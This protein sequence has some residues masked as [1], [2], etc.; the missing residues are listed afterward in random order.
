M[1][2]QQ[3]AL[4]VKEVLEHDETILGLAVA[5]S[6]LTDEIDEWSDLDLVVVTRENLN[7]DKEKMMAYANRF[8]NL[9]SGFT[10]EHVGETR[11]LIC[12]Y[13]EPLLHVDIKFVTADEFRERI[14][15]PVLLLDRNN[16]L[17]DI[18]QSTK[19]SFPSPDFQWIEDRFWIWIHYGL[20]KIGRGEYF[21]ALDFMGFLR[22]SVFGP[23]LHLR[24]NNLPRGVRKVET[25]LTAADFKLLSGTIAIHEKESLLTAVYNATELYKSLRIDLYDD[26]VSLNKA[27]VAVMTYFSSLR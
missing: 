11:L 1:I 17:Q 24:N 3:F 16:V 5:G 12:L 19:A 18:I 6:W 25:T 23:L 8:G 27:E 13:D 15:N 4:K 26:Q 21:E 10:G 9:L 7:A 14:E 20:Q 2:Q 22:M